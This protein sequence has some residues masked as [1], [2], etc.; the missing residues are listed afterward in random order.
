MRLSRNI[1]E[2]LEA[3][4]GDAFF[5]LSLDR[6]ERNFDAFQSALRAIYPR[7]SLAYSYKTNYL[8]PV[9]RAVDARG[10]YA[11]VVSRFEYDL[12]RRIGVAPEHIV[13]NGPLKSADDLE[14]ALL[15]GALVNL[16]GPRELAAVQA[17]ARKHADRHFTL[18]LRCNLAL[19]GVSPSR[20]GFDT[21]SDLADALAVLR[22]LPNCTVAGL[23]CH[24]SAERGLDSYAERVDRL[25]ALADEHF[26]DAP[27]R[28]LDVGGGFFGEL[29]PEL[30]TRFA[31]RPPSYEDYAEVVASRFVAR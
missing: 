24:T 26:P 10:G 23:H 1:L 11:E 30:R 15:E 18:G 16:D 19:A 14:R 12:A 2:R 7:A 17:L 31:G 29:P 8:P 28:F 27:P 5:L 3:E 4:H 9:C 25:I 22:A 20:F 21:A 13:F 6:F